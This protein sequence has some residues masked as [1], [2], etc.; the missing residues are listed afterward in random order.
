[1]NKNRAPFPEY[2]D[3]TRM[4]GPFELDEAAFIVG[5]I[6]LSLV[7]GFALA[8]NVAIAMVSGMVGGVVIALIIKS[9]KKNFAEGYLFHMAYV[10]GLKHP[11]DDNPKAKIKY[12]NYYKKKIKIMPSGYVTTLV[13]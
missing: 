1:M 12:P 11:M 4:F 3:K 13:E 8:I 7:L 9:I 5:G 10:K 2:I 6:G